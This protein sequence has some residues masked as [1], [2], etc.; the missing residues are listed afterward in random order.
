MIRNF[1]TPE[2]DTSL[3]ED[4]IRQFELDWQTGSRPDIAKYLKDSTQSSEL[5]IE[6]VQIELELRYRHHEMPQVE[7]YFERFPQLLDDQDVVIDLIV[8]EFYLRNRFGQAV[9]RDEFLKRFPERHEVLQKRFSSNETTLSWTRGRHRRFPRVLPKIP[10]YVIEEELGQGG[11]GAVY[12]ATQTALQ[13]AVAIKTLL[14]G[15]AATDDLKKRFR[16]EA[17]AIA[18]LNHPHLVPVYEVG[19]WKPEGASA[20]IPYFVMKYYAGGSLAFRAKGADSDLNNHVRIMETISLAVHH[21]HQRGIL[22]RD[23]KPSNILLDEN[24]EPHVVDFGL[25]GRFD[26]NDPKSMTATIMGTPAYMAPEQA[27]SPSQV[28]TAADVYG[29]GAILYHLL[30]GRPPFQAE[31]PLA[32]LERVIHQEPV[33]PSLLNPKIPRDLDTIC[34]KCLEKD[35]AR[36]YESSVALALD[37]ERY[38]SGKSIMARPLQTW[39]RAWRTVLRHPIIASLAILTLAMLIASI[40]VLSLSFLRIRDKEQET[41]DALH[42]EKWAHS[43]LINT[44]NREQQLLYG[45]RISSVGRLWATNQL[46]QAWAELDDCPARYRGWEWRYFNGLRGKSPTTISMPDGFIQCI[47]FLSDQQIV[48]GDSMGMITI[49]DWEKQSPSIGWKASEKTLRHLAVYPRNKWLAV[50]DE[51]Q[52][53]V[54]NYESKEKVAQLSG[55]TWVAF[56]RDGAYLA[57]VHTPDARNSSDAIVWDTATWKQKWLLHAGTKGVLNGTFSPDSKTLAVGGSDRKVRRWNL[58][59]GK[60]AGS[61]WSR[62][63]PSFRLAYLPDGRHLAEALPSAMMWTDPQT[64]KELGRFNWPMVTQPLVLTGRVQVATG[65]DPA[66][67][68]FSGPSHDIQIWDIRQNRSLAMFRGHTMHIAGLEFSTDGKR[69][70]SISYDQTTRIWEINQTPEF[71]THGSINQA[72]H[73]TVLS[74]DGQYLAI[75]PHFHSK[76]PGIDQVT[77]LNTLDG[78]E[79]GQFQ[80]LGI[81]AFTNDGRLLTAQATGGVKCWNLKIKEEVWHSWTPTQLCL[82]LKVNGDDKSI[83]TAHVNGLIQ[84]IDR[85]TGKVTS[86]FSVGQQIFNTVVFS[87]RANRLAFVG[88]H[89]VEVWDMASRTKMCDFPMNGTRK[90]AFSN[91]GEIVATA[92]ADRVIRLRQAKTGSVLLTFPGHPRTINSLALNLDGKRLV[93]SCADGFIRLWDI[94]TGLELAALP[95]QFEENVLVTWD[96]TNDQIVAVDSKVHIWQAGKSSVTVK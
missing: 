37:L 5:L 81:A 90:I 46:P 41:S 26:P 54:W 21:A 10:G 52:L 49:W 70:A 71:Q 50:C 23:L 11:M 61:P 66:L 6:L 86:D 88:H 34:L 74:P 35:P 65:P 62:P 77:V 1:T 73:D 63:F 67:I 32:M 84:F 18:R 16:N 85:G 92:E 43:E 19:E 38:R 3:G 82:S 55:S 96:Q 42:R 2:Y 39:E 13:R 56:S 44:F 14:V 75:I 24:G 22:H 29:L 58:E 15:A 64:G 76:T 31:T 47:G 40:A 53:T 83:I 94:E 78:T 93:S 60:E 20:T 91:D 79:V 27:R 8:T 45:K 48:T 95:G 51:D 87:P 7:E 57:S 30:T 68:A 9:T 4:A 25:A 17:E 89:G 72:F 59:D 36:R 69:L 28:T 33:R 80:G 12:R